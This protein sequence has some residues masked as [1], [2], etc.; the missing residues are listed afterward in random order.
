MRSGLA[1]ET[2]AD[3]LVSEKSDMGIEL[4]GEIAFVTQAGE[5]AEQTV[6]GASQCA[7]YALPP[8][9]ARK[10]ATIPAAWAH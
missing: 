6:P 9:S 7:V 2:A 4:L 5:T 8:F 1:S 10:R 3:V